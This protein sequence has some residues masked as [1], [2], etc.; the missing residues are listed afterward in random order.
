VAVE[1]D[2]SPVIGEIAL[3]DQGAAR[4]TPAVSAGLQL[5]AVIGG[6]YRPVRLIARGGMG[7]VYE[8][9]HAN[10]GE[11]LALKLMLAR[12]LLAPDLVARFQREARIHSSVK[13]EN[14][15][16]VLDA[17]VAPELD[18]APFLVMELLSGQD[19]ERICL[20]RKPSPTEVLDW[21]RQLGTALDKAHDE[22]IVHRDLKPENLFLAARDGLPPIVKVLDFGIAK[23]ATETTGH[24]TAT[25]QILGT[26]RYMAPEQAVGAK[27]VSAAADRFALGL[28]A[29]RLLSG[30]HYFT[31]ENWVGLLRDVGRGPTSRPSEMGCDQGAAFDA[32]FA[33]ACALAPKDR[34]ATCAEQIE[35]LARALEG[36]PAR[37]S[38]WRG[39]R[40]W[41]PLGA[42]GVAT[43]IVWAVGHR[44]GATPAPAT[45]PAA[46]SSAAAGETTKGSAGASP[47]AVVSAPT[48]TPP[49]QATETSRPPRESGA[50]H[51]PRRRAAAGPN[52]GTIAPESKESRK[53]PK[54][55][56]WD[57][58]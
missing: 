8:V 45:P 9:V 16:R 46:T 32:W 35:A 10:T 12:S 50:G 55:P 11:H 23:M 25:G 36:G 15:V 20:E 57:E 40:L 38:N 34:F 3:P 39:S 5:P 26:P 17:D 21:L 6:K 37:M 4:P 33:R 53:D 29:F 47:P 30:R 2:T 52:V 56:T 22:G 48:S 44:R 1:E 49:L 58:P 41:I 43:T 31:G 18:D 28:I 27:Q 24:S 7:A 42:V 54:D 14:V 13:S 19:F 51:R